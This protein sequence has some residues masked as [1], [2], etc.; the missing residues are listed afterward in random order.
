MM[1]QLCE[2]SG[3]ILTVM[4]LKLERA[5][6]FGLPATPRHFCVVGLRLA[7]KLKPCTVIVLGVL[8][9]TNDYSILMENLCCIVI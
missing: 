8:T 6:L 7:L 5:T 4:S 3:Y 9:L 1:F 2:N